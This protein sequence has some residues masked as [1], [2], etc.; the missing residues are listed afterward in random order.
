M[1]T[2]ITT[3]NDIKTRLDTDYYHPIYTELEEK[4]AKDN[5]AILSDYIENLSGGATPS[6]KK[7]DVYYTDN[8]NE[9]I[10][11]IRVQNLSQAGLKVDDVKYITPL[12]HNG[13]LQRSQSNGGDLLVKITGVGRM[14]VSSVV[15]ENYECNIN[16]HIV[17]I[18]TKDRKTSEVL[19]T[20]LNT[21][22]GEK[23]AS[24]RS[25]GGTRPALDY[26]ALK[27]IPI[28]FDPKIVDI[29]QS[30]YQKKQE[31][32]REAEKLAKNNYKLFLEKLSLDF[33]LPKQQ[34]AFVVSIDN[35]EG[36]RIDPMFYSNVKNYILRTITDSSKTVKPLSEIIVDSS[37][38]YWGNDETKKKEKEVA[39]NVVRNTNF[40]N[41]INLDLE[42]V[43]IR[44]VEPSK[45]KNRK[46]S[47][48]DLLIEKSGGSPA[49]PV[50]RVCLWDREMS[51]E[52]IFS[53]FLQKISIDQEQCLPEYLFVYLRAL[54]NIGL[55][56]YFQNQ[57]TGIK[58]LI[59]EEFIGSPIIL[60]TLSVQKELAGFVLDRNK[61]II[62]LE[63][64]AEKTI[65][66]A[67][68]QVEE[69]ILGK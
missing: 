68:A 39:V 58:N 61:E 21:D 25:T 44:Y 45:I 8:P 49:Q 41:K 65:E 34:Q 43:A 29:M 18:K 16:Q 26:E 40:D 4:V 3:L 36:N 57:T 5:S 52:Y 1:K 11:F 47:K 54:Y 31:L 53:N 23:L 42:D 17:R 12:V 32:E 19:A 56:E 50:G 37:A 64:K 28:V 20:Y 6:S 59:W 67:K 22:I 2:F 15:P 55:M 30:A 9:G 46:L 24:R 48:G 7:K 38:G 33:D 63:E 51:E 10:P 13:M 62:R 35:V 66:Q 69:I 14:A 27:S 60:P